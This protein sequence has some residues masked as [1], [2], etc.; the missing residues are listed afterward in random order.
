MESFA[1]DIF[2]IIKMNLECLWQTSYQCYVFL[3]WDWFPH[4]YYDSCI[5]WLTCRDPFICLSVSLSVS[6]YGLLKLCLNFK[7]RSMT[8]TLNLNIQ[9]QRQLLFVMF[10]LLDVSYWLEVFVCLFFKVEVRFQSK[11]HSVQ[12]IVVVGGI[13]FAYK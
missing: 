5:I 10:S 11:S 4:Y 12:V 1:V 7:M 2:I 9:Y 8:L 6:H 3:H 13:L